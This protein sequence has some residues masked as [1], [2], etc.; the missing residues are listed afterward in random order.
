VLQQ[1]D[2]TSA[3]TIQ[4]GI[5]QHYRL[6]SAISRLLTWDEPGGDPGFFKFGEDTVCYG[7][8]SSVPAARDVSGDLFDAEKGLRTRG[9]QVLVPFD[10]SELIENLCKERYVSV[11]FTQ[12]PGMLRS[13]VVRSCYYAVRGLMPRSVRRRFQ[14]M[15]F[16]GWSDLPFPNWPVDFTVDTL[17]EN[18][19]KAILKF[20]DTPSIPFIWF[21]PE[22]AQSCMIMTHDV[23]V[24][25][26]RDFV[27]RLMDMNDNFGLKSSFQV[28]PEK[29][30]PVPDTLVNMIRNRGFEFNVHDLNHD[31]SLF[32]EHEEFLRRAAKINEY[33]RK[34]DS[35]GFRA[36][37][38]Y[39]NQDWYDAFD[40]SY[41]MSVPNVAHL[42]PQRGGCC[43]VRPYFNGRIL[44]LPLTCAQD[45]S[46]FHILNDYSIGVWKKQLAAIHAKNG[47]SSF[48][49]HPDYIIEPRA[50]GVYESLLRFLAEQR[51]KLNF[52]T[53]LPRE[54]D[55]W[56]RAR[57][58][59]QLVSRDGQWRI[60]GPESERARVA[61]ATLKGDQ[62][63]YRI[64]GTQPSV[65]A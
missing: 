13:S 4:Q 23:E 61:Y 44:E 16:K 54:V 34:Y 59:M 20:S 2:M 8:C 47:L 40:F 3:Y 42:E 37:A 65:A 17:R 60:E 15:Y 28:I 39:H 33:I 43:T 14:R 25:A 9:S 50:R 5:A 30:Y 63:V 51:Q 49:V 31:G 62:L 10:P 1:V 36:G 19:L 24:C 45:Y 26:G 56:W 64:D 38:M 48:L 7:R 29:R 58:Q 41:D 32:Q 18:L 27:P 55:K 6:P 46:L 11:V 22:G 35:R 57:D 21:W 53:T 12:Q 52:W